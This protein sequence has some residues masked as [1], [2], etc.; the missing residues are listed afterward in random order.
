MVIICYESVRDVTFKQFVVHLF[1]LP[2]MSVATT[3]NLGRLNAEALAVYCE[4]GRVLSIKYCNV[5]PFD[6]VFVDE[7]T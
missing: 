6:L 5:A 2:F 4:N 1:Y 3:D 7:K